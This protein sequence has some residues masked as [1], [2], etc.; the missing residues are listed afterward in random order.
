MKTPHT[1][2]SND[3]NLNDGESLPLEPGERI[4]LNCNF[5]GNPSP[6]IIW[7]KNEKRINS[8]ID[9]PGIGKRKLTITNKR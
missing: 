1:F 4:R 7:Y 3:A 5:K 8:D 9:T 2:Y 6:E